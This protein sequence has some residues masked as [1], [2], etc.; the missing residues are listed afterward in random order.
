MRL[1]KFKLIIDKIERFLL[2]LFKFLKILKVMNF[3][4]F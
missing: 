1:Y 2:L 4:F 3:N